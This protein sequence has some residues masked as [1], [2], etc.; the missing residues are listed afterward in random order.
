MFNWRVVAGFG[1]L[2]L[3]VIVF[4]GAWKLESKTGANAVKPDDRIKSGEFVVDVPQ[5]VG[6]DLVIQCDEERFQN[7][8]KR[9]RE[10]HLDIK[11]EPIAV[12]GGILALTAWN[13]KNG[14]PEELKPVERAITEALKRHSP[15]R[16]V[17]TAHSY[18]LLYDVIA[19][20]QNK[21]SEVEA[22]QLGDLET[23]RDLIRRLFPNAQVDV[24]YAKV[25][26][27]KLRFKPILKEEVK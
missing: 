14:M 17:L 13:W 1:V 18:C 5:E 22:R 27:D 19:A 7:A 10:E 2:V 23:A 25:D 15:R 20:W 3:A 8:Y 6:I 24:Y 11:T 12:P 26:G 4:L 9:F 16:V 21:A